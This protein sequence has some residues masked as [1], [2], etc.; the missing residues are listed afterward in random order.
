MNLDVALPVA[1]SIF[2][3]IGAGVGLT[4]W[5]KTLSSDPK[6]LPGEE[7]SRMHRLAV[8]VGN[9]GFIL[10]LASG[11]AMHRFGGFAQTDPTPFLLGFGLAGLLPMLALL[12]IP[13]VRGQRP[14]EALYAFSGGR[15]APRWA[16]YAVLGAF[17][18]LLPLGV[19]RLVA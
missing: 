15:S 18:A 14:I 12:G 19:H 17:T 9:T 2:G 11:Y 8:G 7:V 10:G 4:R 1:S 3:A 16:T 5:E 6:D 13:R